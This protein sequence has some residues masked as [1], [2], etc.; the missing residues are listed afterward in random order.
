MTEPLLTPLDALALVQLRSLRDEA[1]RASQRLAPATRLFAVVLLDAVNEST[2]NMVATSLDIDYD[3]RQ[4]FDGLK[5]RIQQELGQRWTIVSSTWRDVLR[6]HQSRNLAQHRGISPDKEA[7]PGWSEVAT[8]SFAL[9]L[10]RIAFGVNLDEVRL[11]DAIADAKLR[12]LLQEAETDLAE[13]R[14]A[15]SARKTFEAFHSASER[16]RRQSQKR[17]ALA[18]RKPIR[19]DFDESNSMKYLE[20]LAQLGADAAVYQIFSSSP[21]EYVWFRKL[22]GDR[23]EALDEDEVRRALGFVF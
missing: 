3:N 11:S 14:F 1:R 19:F 18:P 10:V 23:P 6:L 15:A 8:E 7:I 13:G 9:T 21:S 4:N 20:S 22:Q 5:S 17:P 12:D 16:W 2:M